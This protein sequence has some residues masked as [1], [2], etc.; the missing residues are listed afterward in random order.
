MKIIQNNK[1]EILYM[2]LLAI[3]LFLILG[4]ALIEIMRV[5]EAA[6]QIRAAG[7]RAIVSGITK[8]WKEVFSGVR[9]GYSAS[10]AYEEA[11]GKWKKVVSPISA[12]VEIKKDLGLN[13][14]GQKKFGKGYFYQIKDFKI[15]MIEAL[16]QNKSQTLEVKGVIKTEMVLGI[17][18]IS[19]SID[20]PIQAKYQ[21]I[22]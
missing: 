7:E 10:F 4:V 20:I 16:W 2:W 6:W 14:D 9:E 12:F 3:C 1:G 5:R 19:F 17:G 8:Q 18:G 13:A 22:F 21:R 15:T 11:S